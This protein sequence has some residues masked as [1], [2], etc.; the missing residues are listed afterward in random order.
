MP[1]PLATAGVA[2]AVPGVV[3]L[4]IE[5][6]QFLHRL[7]KDVK[8]AST[9]QQQRARNLYRQLN[10][11]HGEFKLLNAK[12]PSFQN[13]F[14]YESERM[15]VLLSGLRERIPQM[16]TINS[17][18]WAFF[19]RKGVDDYISEVEKFHQQFTLKFLLLSFGSLDLKPLVAEV[20]APSTSTSPTILFLTRMKKVIEDRQQFRYENVNQLPRKSFDEIPEPT[21][22]ITGAELGWLRTQ[23]A[24]F[25]IV[26]ERHY[27]NKAEHVESLDRVKG[28]AATL[29]A[30]NPEDRELLAS[31]GIPRCLG[32]VSDDDNAT[33]YR[34]I[35]HTGPDTYKVRSLRRILLTKPTFPRDDRVQLARTLAR[36]VYFTHISQYVHKDVRAGNVLLCDSEAAENR[37]YPATLGRALLVGF[38]DSRLSTASSQ[39]IGTKA[40]E[41]EMYQHPSRLVESGRSKHNF[42][43]DVYSLGVCLLEIG[44]WQSIVVP[45]DKDVSEQWK[46]NPDWKFLDK[47]PSERADGYAKNAQTRL[48]HD[49]GRMYANAV[50]N[51]LRFANANNSMAQTSEGVATG[52]RYVEEVLTPLETI[53]M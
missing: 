38:S 7:F 1:D 30:E 32:F 28:V 19:S 31:M 48:A 33:R 6:I 27:A 20:S 15:H 17:A 45:P 50:L 4:S 25:M 52:M 41:R 29:L 53:R 5:Y 8:H 9:D 36:A 35:Y 42:S 43:H 46:M 24:G 16:G 3:H 10:D 18:S 11:I 12:P 26:E 34:L 23:S 39:L 2:L 14:E 13:N 21:T 44:L 37:R 49:M 47:S 22:K 40:T 51:C